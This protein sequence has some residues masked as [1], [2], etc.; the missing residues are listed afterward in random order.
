MNKIFPADS[1]FLACRSNK[2]IDNKAIDGIFCSHCYSY[3]RIYVFLISDEILV[4]SICE[5]GHEEFEL[6]KN[7]I[8]NYRKSYIKDCQI[9]YSHININEL[10]YCYSCSSKNIICIECRNKYHPSSNIKNE[11]NHITIRFILRCNYCPLHNNIKTYYCI[12]C[13]KYF[14]K[15]YDKKK[16]Y[17]HAVID[18]NFNKIIY[19]KD[20]VK[21]IIEKEEKENKE[22]IEKINNLIIKMRNNFKEILSYKMNVIYLK[23]NIINS[24]KLSNWNYNKTKNLKFIR[25]YF[26]NNKG[27]KSLFSKINISSRIRDN[28]FKLN[29]KEKKI[30]KQ[31]K[32]IQ[33]IK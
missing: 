26:D 30:L 7:F 14:C 17:S 12:Y 1:N 33:Y 16:L 4:Q 20:R 15:L 19:S 21:S 25:K 13:K 6:L 11:K 24:Y 29:N 27:V 3:I 5:K 31:I 2:N 23:R 9:C 8:K 28:Y 10:Y 32:T 22:D 18:L